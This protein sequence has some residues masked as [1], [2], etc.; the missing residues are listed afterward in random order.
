MPPETI[1]AYRDHGQPAARLE[2]GAAEAAAQ[3]RQL[4]ELGIDLAAVTQELEDEGVKKF[5]EPYD[6][7][8]ATL[9]AEIA[10]CK[11]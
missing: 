9:R 4:A 7:L 6:K 10:A 2:E 11:V 8:I 5:I 1:D 3:L